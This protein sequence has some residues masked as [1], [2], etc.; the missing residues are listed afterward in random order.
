MWTKKERDYNTIKSTRNI[1]ILKK[2]NE[3][4]KDSIFKPIRAGKF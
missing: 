3:G 4:I 2:E 1:F